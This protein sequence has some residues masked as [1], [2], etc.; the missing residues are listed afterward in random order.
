MASLKKRQCEGANAFDS[1]L[2]GG[3][4]LLGQFGPAVHDLASESFCKPAWVR[5]SHEGDWDSSIDTQGHK[6]DLR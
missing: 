2:E 4:E 5:R 1:I 3:N 6:L